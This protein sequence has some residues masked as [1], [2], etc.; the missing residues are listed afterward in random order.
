MKRMI[1]LE[2]DPTWFVRPNGFD[3]AGTIHGLG[4]TRRVL[5]H[6][7]ALAEALGF[8]AWEREALTYAAL[9]HDIGR[10]ND[11]ADYFHGA[12]SAG[13]AVTLGLHRGIEPR[14]YET[15]LY[16]V[17]H[18]C[19][20]E[21]HGERAAAHV[22][23]LASRL[24]E[25]ERWEQVDPQAA[26]RVFRALKDADGLDRVRLGDLDPER[27]RCPEAKARVDSAWELL[28]EIP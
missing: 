27:L 11:W 18:H 16:A 17:T 14:I 5:V 4:H 20:D 26:L 6:A 8:S 13:K 28:R 3:A 19:G 7:E 9:W 10:T 23:F 12:K 15:A 24:G 22:R 21:G 25:A 2:P 1:P